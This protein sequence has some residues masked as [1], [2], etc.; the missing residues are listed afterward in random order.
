MHLPVGAQASA[1]QGRAVA[2]GVLASVLSALPLG[3][4][5]VW[6]M[7]VIGLGAGGTLG[8]YGAAA[9]EPSSHALWVPVAVFLASLGL[10]AV[11]IWI[12]VSVTRR[13][14][15]RAQPPLP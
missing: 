6:L 4:V 5:W 3:V 7:V 12:G 9:A 11:D 2:A 13:R 15:R 14:Q 10:L 8:G 1:G